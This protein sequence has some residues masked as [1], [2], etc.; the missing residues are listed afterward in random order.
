MAEEATQEGQEPS[1]AETPAAESQPV[2]Q[3]PA[4]G[5]QGKPT[6]EPQKPA[7]G[8]PAPTGEPKQEQKE[9]KPVSRRSAQYRIQQLTRENAELKRQQ[10]PQNTQ[11]DTGDENAGNDDDLSP[12]A[13]RRIGTLENQVKELSNAHNSANS[14]N[15]QAA[16][17]AELNEVFSGSKAAHRNKYEDSIKKLWEDKDYRGVAAESLFK[18]LDY[19]NAI[20]RARAEAIEEYKKAELE[21]KESS[22][23]GSSN[24]SNRTGNHGKSVADMTDDEFKAHNDRVKAGQA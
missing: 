14:A 4:E 23:S 10:K 11:D 9:F 20:E 16:D 21:A 2:E 12:D 15:A 19:D 1:S 17:S 22:A 6:G 3:T 8:T 13:K 18:M 7:E 5:E 24:T